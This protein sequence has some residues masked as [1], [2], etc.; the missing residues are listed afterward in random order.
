MK[1]GRKLILGLVSL[2]IVVAA[3]LFYSRP[4]AAPEVGFPTLAGENLTT[5]GL[6]G[7]VVLVNFWATSCVICVKEMPMLVATHRKYAPRGYATV[8]VA[9]SYD[10]PNFVAEYAQKNALPF[11]VALDIS[12]DIA[13]HFGDVRLT[14]TSFVIDRRGRIVKQ[15]LGQPDEAELHSLVEKA[16]AEP[17]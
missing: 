15:Y 4:A 1:I 13:R 2:A 12:G 14:P 7:K 17:A 5:S 3:A 10:H 9:M 6:R 16:L 8:A 11:H